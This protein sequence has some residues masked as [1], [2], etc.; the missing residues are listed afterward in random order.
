[1]MP[2]SSAMLPIRGPVQSRSVDR[3][4]RRLIDPHAER[5]RPVQLAIGAV[6]DVQARGRGRVDG[7]AGDLVD[8]GVRLGDADPVRQHDSVDRGRQGRLVEDDAAVDRTVGHDRELEP[9]GARS[10]QRGERGIGHDDR[11]PVE[12]ESQLDGAGDLIVGRIAADAVARSYGI[13]RRDHRA[14]R[15]CARAR[16]ARTPA[17]TRP[18]RRRASR[19]SRGRSSLVSGRRSQ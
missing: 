7:R 14:C 18:A 12:R 9:G 10:G 19:P 1:M 11:P 4:L 15:P 16:C 3:E 2:G 5:L 6:A 8:P 13:A 17:R